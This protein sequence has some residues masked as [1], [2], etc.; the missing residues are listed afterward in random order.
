MR[1]D[2]SSGGSPLT[3]EIGAEFPIGIRGESNLLI[4]M[5]HCPTALLT[6]NRSPTDD[7]TFITVENSGLPP[8]FSER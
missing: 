3:I 4:I 8:L 6:N 5:L 2:D 1:I 7:I